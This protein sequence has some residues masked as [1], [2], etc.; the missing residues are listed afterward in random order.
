MK[1]KSLQKLYNEGVFQAQEH[2]R[3]AEQRKEDYLLVDDIAHKIESIGA[4]ISFIGTPNFDGRCKIYCCIPSEFGGATTTRDKKTFSQ[5]VSRIAHALDESP[6]IDVKQGEYMADFPVNG[7]HFYTVSPV[8]CKLV[9]HKETKE[10][11]TLKPHP[12]C[13]AALKELENI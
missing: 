5:F 2:L 7:V 4:S 9:E 13:L 11:V 1:S 3:K 8:D 10:V 6:D 12:S